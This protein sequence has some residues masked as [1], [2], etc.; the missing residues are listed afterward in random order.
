MQ[1][2]LRGGDE[3]TFLAYAHAIAGTPWGRG[4][5]PHGSYQLQTELFAAQIKL[6]NL[7]PTALRVTQVGISMLGI[8]LIVAAVYDLAGPR[9]ARLDRVGG[10]ARAGEH[11][12]QQLALEGADHAARH[13]LGGA[14]VDRRSGGGWIRSGCCCVRSAG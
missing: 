6:F 14:R 13:R 8:L 9:A 3:S 5:L 10:G 11:L 7:S 1:D 4:F 12:L 2:Q